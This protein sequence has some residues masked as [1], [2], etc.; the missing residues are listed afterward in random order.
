VLGHCRRGDEAIVG[1]LSHMVQVEIGS[2]AGLAAVQLRP[3]AND[4]NG[5]LDLGAIKRTIRPL[6]NAGP[7]TALVCIENTHNYC[8]G[9]PLSVSYTANVAGLAHG[10]GATL[11]VDGARIFNAA[12]ALETTAAALAADADSVSFCLS[13][14]LACPV[15]SLLC[16]SGEFIQTA[17]RWRRAVGG[18]MRQAGIIAAAGVVAL[19]EM[20]DR[21]A[22]DHANA[23]LLADGLASIPGIQIDASLV[24][25]NIVFF[26]PPGDV[27]AFLRRL[28]ERG[29]LA[30]MAVG[31][32]RMLTHYGIEPGD[33]EYAL[34]T[35]REVVASP[36]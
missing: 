19:D 2:A 20:V 30:G 25:T 21:L 16:G 1:D 4:E 29:I 31:S 24:R 7:R 17:R 33:I 12:I 23:R 28:R 5:L 15:G 11:H 27:A 14:G 13:K 9:A 35:V 3:I 6:D 32:V 36:A 26:Q 22:D 10:G 18:G 8:H 34:E